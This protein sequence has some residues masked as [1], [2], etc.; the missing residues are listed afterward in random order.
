M[1]AL[2]YMHWYDWASAFLLY[3]LGS[4]KLWELITGLGRWPWAF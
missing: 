2:D 1:C 4:W 3:V